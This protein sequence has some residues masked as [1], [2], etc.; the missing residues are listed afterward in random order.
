MGGD[1]GYG[2]Y[3]DISEKYCFKQKRIDTNFNTVIHSNFYDENLGNLKNVI[4]SL[5]R[6]TLEE[7]TE[8]TKNL[9]V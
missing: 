4:I 9:E 6:P 5:S 7:I 2:W 8:F 3:D 1:Y